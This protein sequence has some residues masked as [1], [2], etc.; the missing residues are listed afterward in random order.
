M[1]IQPRLDDGER[2][3]LYGAL[4]KRGVRTVSMHGGKDVE[5][6]AMAGLARDNGE[7]V[8]RRM[9]LNLHQ[10]LQGVATERLVVS[11]PVADR[12]VINMETGEAVGWAPSYDT[13]LEA[14]ILNEVRSRGGKELTLQAAMGNAA[15][16]NAEVLA[17]RESVIIAKRDTDLLRAK[18]LPSAGLGVRHGGTR[19]SDR[20]NPLS[21]PAKAHEGTYGL[22]LRQVLFSDELWSNLRARRIS[23]QAAELDLESRRLDATEAAAGAVFD[24]LTAKALYEIEKENVELTENNLEMAR[25]RVEIGAA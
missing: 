16:S 6:G 15:N 8:A 23:E 13:V 18:L 4:K 14:D 10:M 22:E 9:A 21:T 3:A 2:K 12:L 20:I 11:L 24:Y 7:V 25:L 19:F 17:E 5:L 1:A